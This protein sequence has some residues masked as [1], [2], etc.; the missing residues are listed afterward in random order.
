MRERGENQRNRKRD[1]WDGEGE[2]EEYR[3]VYRYI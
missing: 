1:M 3:A 2:G